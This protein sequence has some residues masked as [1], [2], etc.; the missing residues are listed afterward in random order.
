MR[1]L[2]KKGALELSINAI[3]IIILAMTLLGLGLAFVRGLFTRVNTVSD[4]SFDKM[5]E[6]LNIDLQN[7]NA[8]VLFSKKRLVLERGGSSLEGLGIKNDGDASMTYGVRIATFD[9]PSK[10]D[11]TGE[12]DSVAGWFTYLEGDEQYTVPAADTHVSS[13]QINVPRRAATGLYLLKILVYQGA[14]NEEDDVPCPGDYDIDGD[15]KGCS[16]FGQT[17]LFLTIS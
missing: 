16:I 7:Q 14:W 1:R 4:E 8:P 6:Q 17:E 3:V 9:C 13:M 2:N 11:E 10:N 12:C 15:G 5:E